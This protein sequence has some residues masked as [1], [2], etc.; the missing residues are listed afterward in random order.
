M[1]RDVFAGNEAWFV[2][3]FQFRAQHFRQGAG[4]PAFFGTDKLRKPR[5]AM[6]RRAFYAPQTHADGFVGGAP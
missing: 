1:P 2:S 6:A 3:S 5:T 4:Q